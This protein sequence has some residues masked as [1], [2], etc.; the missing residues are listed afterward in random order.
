MY[1]HI[2][3]NVNVREGQDAMDLLRSENDR[4][5]YDAHNGV[6][7]VPESRWAQAQKAEIV[8]QTILGAPASDDRNFDHYEAFDR[9]NSLRGQSFGH[10][11][12]LGCGPFTNLRIIAN[13]CKI[14]ECDLLDPLI[15]EYLGHSHTSFT[16]SNL[17]AEI[18]FLTVL[19]KY[20][21]L[22]KIIKRLYGL[23][24]LLRAS[25]RVPVCDLFKSSIENMKS[26]RIYDMVVMIN[27]VEH[28]YDV[29]KIFQQILS[30]TEPGSVF[31]FHDKCYNAKSVER[32]LKTLFDA[33]HPLKVDGGLYRAFLKDHFDEIYCK[34]LA[35]GSEISLLYFIGRRK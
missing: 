14:R 6:A 33:A 22:K 3:D 30:I 26:V 27:V 31:V 29:K 21:I 7:R 23:E 32:S 16:R 10:V 1:K 18:P 19:P 4:I 20:R 35:A 5:Y 8:H 11:I 24:P 15:N 2:D 17:Y 9:Y 28:C 13:V 12:E 34:E 25:R